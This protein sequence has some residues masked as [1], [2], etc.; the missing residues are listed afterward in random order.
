MNQTVEPLSEYIG[1]RYCEL[2]GDEI[3]HVL[4]ERNYPDVG[5]F[6]KVDGVYRMWDK[7]GK[8]YKFRKREWS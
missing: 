1:K 8:Y 5:H 3:L 4:D 7:D 2:S 6:E